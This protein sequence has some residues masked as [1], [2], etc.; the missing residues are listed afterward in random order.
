MFPTLSFPAKS[1]SLP[2]SLTVELPETR[3]YAKNKHRASRV[4]DRPCTASPN[5]TPY[6]GAVRQMSA[7]ERRHFHGHTW[8][9]RRNSRV[10]REERL[11]GVLDPPRLCGGLSRTGSEMKRRDGIRSVQGELYPEGVP[12]LMGFVGEG[13][14][15]KV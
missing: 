13:S 4:H 9:R 11:R 6:P 3:V 8:K 5:A 15:L 10:A 7:T 2:R 1:T 12:N 14:G